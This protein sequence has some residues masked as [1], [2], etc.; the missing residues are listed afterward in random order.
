MLKPQRRFALFA[1]CL[2]VILAAVLFRPG[3]GKQLFKETRT[4]LHTVVA[5]TVLSS[6]QER[7]KTAIDAAYEELHRLGRLLNFYADDSELSLIN[8][9]AGIKPVT[10]SKDTLEIIQ[11]ALFVAEQTEGAFD[12]T[13]GPLVKLWDFHKKLRP[14]PVEIEKMRPLV[15]YK[16]IIVDPAASTVFL[17]KSGVKIDLGGIIK[18]FAADKA[19]EI[20]Q[21]NGIDDGIVAVAGDIKTFGKQPDGRAWHVGIQNPRQEGETDQL[22]ATVDLQANGISTSGDYQRFFMED[23]VRYHHLLDPRTGH[24]ANLCQSVTIIAPTATMSDALA[25]GIFILGPEK[26]MAALTRLAM[27]GVIVDQQ[28]KILMTAGIIP[29]VHL[30][31]RQ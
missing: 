4:A 24:P 10:V 8:Q 29:S 5:V 19:V 13:V 26:G 15:G 17:Q 11:A 20:L 25:T 12:V 16:N 7:A 6:S 28:G 31:R 9:N 21:K 22:L 23:N 27:E 1:F 14:G 18:G 30:V 3:K 2:L